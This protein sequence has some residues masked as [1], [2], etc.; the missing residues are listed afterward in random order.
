MQ[1][2][3]P[4][5]NSETRVIEHG[6]NELP[7]VGLTY[8]TPGLS[9]PDT[10]ALEVAAAILGGGE[11]SRLYHTLVYKQQLAADVGASADSREDASLFEINAVLSE[12][13]KPE[14]V[15]RSLLAEIRKLQDQPVVKLELDKA[16]NQLITNL[17]R[18]RETNEG[19][20]QVLGEATVLL[21]HPEQA[22]LDGKVQAVTVSTSRSD[23]KYFTSSNRLVLYYLPETSKT[24]RPGS[25]TN[26]SSASSASLYIGCR[27]VCSSQ[28][29]PPPPAKPRSVTFPKPVEQPLPNG[30]RVIIAERRYAVS[31][32]FTRNRMV[33][34]LTL[35]RGVADLT[36]NLLTKGTTTRTATQIAEEVENLGGELRL[37]RDGIMSVTVGV[38]SDKMA[39]LCQYSPMWCD[40]RPLDLT[41]RASASVAHRH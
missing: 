10:D 13:K 30:L 27:S 5:R 2:K 34:K 32:S 26:G 4:S 22:N 15:E 8:L 9:D 38:M 28:T 33:A 11:S 39:L 40:V 29:T 35:D 23:E 37:V 24:R 12:G 14:D 19:T 1:I 25:M 31:D 21:G 41:D 17:F 36:A 18:E 6:I 16:K 7:A 3:E 20:A